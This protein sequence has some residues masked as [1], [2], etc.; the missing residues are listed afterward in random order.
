[1]VY[2]VHVWVYGWK[3][4]W[5]LAMRGLWRLEVMELCL[6]VGMWARELVTYE[7]KSSWHLDY[8]TAFGGAKS[9]RR[10][11]VRGC[12]KKSWWHLD[13]ASYRLSR[14]CVGIWVKE[15]VTFRWCAAFGGWKLWSCV[16][17][18][19][20]GWGSWWHLDDATHSLS[21]TC[22]GI[23]VKDFVTYKLWW[24]LWRLE[25]MAP[26]MWVW[27]RVR[28]ICSWRFDPHQNLPWSGV[29]TRYRCFVQ[30]ALN[31]TIL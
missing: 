31:W 10:V 9:W 2:H 14:M 25:V 20:C 16:C 13:D 29:L 3:S 5:H 24:G 28:G 4:W 7:W 30:L 23:W 12:G 21:C 11:C 27:A 15:F 19:V 17:V 18:W 26:C 1:M 8:G 6:C 22:V